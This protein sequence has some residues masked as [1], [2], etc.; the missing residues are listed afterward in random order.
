MERLPIPR[1]AE[2]ISRSHYVTFSSFFVSRDPLSPSLSEEAKQAGGFN[3]LP[4]DRGEAAAVAILLLL[5]L[6]LSAVPPVLRLSF[7][8]TSWSPIVWLAV[9][10]RCLGR[11]WRWRTKGVKGRRGA[12]ARVQTLGMF[13]GEEGP[14]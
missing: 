14:V 3:L 8:T 10:N 1:G 11:L 13:Q 6:L 12:A 2:L 7:G 4:D 5:L 9:S